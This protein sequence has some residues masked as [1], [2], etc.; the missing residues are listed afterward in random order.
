M[1]SY[2]SHVHAEAHA[3]EL[4]EDAER[5]RQAHLVRTGHGPP[6]RL[7]NSLARVLLG[8]AIRLD[9]GLQATAVQPTTSGRA[10]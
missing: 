1:S 3:A 10:T 7:R 8:L 2:L 5:A 9:H 6:G 4:C